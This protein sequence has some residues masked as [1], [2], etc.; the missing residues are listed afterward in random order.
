[1]VQSHEA[2]AR[3][4]LFYKKSKLETWDLC[5]FRAVR[6]MLCFVYHTLIKESSSDSGIVTK[7]LSV[8]L[9]ILTTSQ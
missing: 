2:V 5:P 9:T 6:N 1:M 8:A 3:Y 4:L 7:Y